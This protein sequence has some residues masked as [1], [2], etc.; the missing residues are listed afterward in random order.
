MDIEKQIQY[1]HQS[2]DEDWDVASNLIDNYKIRHGLFFIHLSLEK[3]LKALICKKTNDIP[4]RIHNLV[5]LCEI[6]DI[7]PND[8]Q[9]D[10]LAEMNAFNIEGRYPDSRI[11]SPDIQT[12]KSYLNKA[13]EVRLWIIQQL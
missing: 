4:P 3:L 10:I 2:S 9:L 6:A 7:N 12:A 5:R 13:K 8:S 1:W 11:Q